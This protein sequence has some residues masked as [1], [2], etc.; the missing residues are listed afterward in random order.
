[1]SGLWP[2]GARA[3]VSLSY[4]DTMPCHRTLVAP[5]LEAHGLRG[6]F[7]APPRDDL[8]Q[9]TDAWRAMAERGHELGNHTL[10]HPCR[11]EVP[12]P[13]DWVRTW[14]NLVNF[15]ADRFRGECRTANFMLSLVDGRSERTYG[16]TC[17]DVW[18]GPAE[19]KQRIE[20][21]LAEMFVAA[22]G[23]CTNAPTDPGTA[24]LFNLG[25]TSGDGHQFKV[26]RQR[27]EQAAEC[28][29]YLLLTF[30][31][32]GPGYQRLQVDTDEHEQL[33]SYLREQAGRLW[34][35]PVI[36]V[37]KWIRDEIQ[38]A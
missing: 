5:A 36:E 9:H 31:G 18:I 17:H 33:L 28:G 8:A 19:S 12:Q 23:E 3:A 4:D 11:R 15:D 29:G 26:W 20:P 1:M 32:I 2:N 22:R 37:A 34:T 13:D 10:F 6:T 35:A 14:N 24:D 38:A 21:L 27:I 16:N 30:H 25:T 7:Y